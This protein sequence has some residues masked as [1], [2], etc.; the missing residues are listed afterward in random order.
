MAAL[1]D[2]N[3]L[4]DTWCAKYGILSGSV[5]GSY[6]LYVAVQNAVRREWVR[7][8]GKTVV[9]PVAA[10]PPAPVP[11]AISQRPRSRRG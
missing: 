8:Q 9:E 1:D 3:P 5:A 10:L 4:V 7:A 2:V 6:N 11:R